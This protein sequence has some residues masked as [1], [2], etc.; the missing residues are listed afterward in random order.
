MPKRPPLHV[1]A[2]ARVL[3]RAR[4][5][6]YNSKR[7]PNEVK[8]YKSALW[9]HIRRQVLDEE[10]FCRSC[11][12]AGKIVRATVVDHIIP[13]SEG[14]SRT[15]RDN[16]QPLCARCHNSKTAREVM[17]RGNSVVGRRGGAG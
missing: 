15:D 16:L 6:D 9:R 11:R 4:H 17:S 7:S 8:F 2:S 5:R 12:N 13:I 14:G 3:K 1:P 10:P